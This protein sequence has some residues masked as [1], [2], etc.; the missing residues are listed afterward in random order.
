MNK[1]NRKLFIPAL[2]SGI[3]LR[4]GLP[5]LGNLIALAWDMARPQL[6]AMVS[7]ELQ[8]VISLVSFAIFFVALYFT[9]EIYIRGAKKGR[10][11]LIIVIA[12]V[13]IGFI[14]TTLAMGIAFDIISGI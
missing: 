13:V 14:G 1:S 3:A 9:Y 5:G 10:K 6:E 12:G 8:I 4:L 2:L 11:G 7:A